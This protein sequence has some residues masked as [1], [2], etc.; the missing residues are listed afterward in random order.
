MDLDRIYAL[1]KRV[2]Q[3]LHCSQKIAVSLSL[4]VTGL[5][6][7]NRVANTDR[8]SGVVFTQD[9]DGGRAVVAGAKVLINGVTSSETETDAAGEYVFTGLPPGSYTLKALAPGL[10]A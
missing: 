3:K 8:V 2:K 6:A 4:L 5:F 10:I 9:A 1:A 7:Q